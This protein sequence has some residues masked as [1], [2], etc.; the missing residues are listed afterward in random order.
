[1]QLASASPLPQAVGGL[2]AAAMQP[3]RPISTKPQLLDD[4]NVDTTFES[5][6]LSPLL[7]KSIQDNFKIDK[8]FPIQA[9]VFHPVLEGRDVVAKS[10]TGSGKTLAFCLPLVQRIVTEKLNPMVDGTLFLILEPTR[11]LAKQVEQ[12]LKRLAPGV[13][14]ASIYGGSSYDVQERAL[15]SGLHF[16]VA[17]PGRL[18]DLMERGMVNLAS[19]RAVV[20]DE[21]DE[22]LKMGFKEALDT[23]L[24][25]TPVDKQ[26]MLFSATVPGWVMHAANRLCR[27]PVFLDAVG[28]DAVQTS[29][30]IQHY[31]LPFKSSAE[32][33]RRLVAA[34]RKLM[35]NKGIADISRTIVFC[36]T[37]AMCADVST[38]LMSTDFRGRMSVFSIHGDV[39]QNQRER[40]LERFRSSNRGVL[41]AT[42]VAARGIDVSNVELVVCL[43]VPNQ[44]EQY[45]HRS[46]RTGRAG[47]SGNCVLMFT[48]DQ[49]EDVLRIHKEAGAN[50]RMLNV[51]EA[52]SFAGT[53]ADQH[54]KDS[55]KLLNVLPA[56]HAS[57]LQLAETILAKEG[58]AGF[59]K[60]LQNQLQR[61]NNDRP[62]PES[63]ITGRQ[64]WVTCQTKLSQD[65][66]DQHL[67][68]LG[69]HSSK[70]TRAV[71]TKEDTTY[72]DVRMETDFAAMCKD[73][74]IVIAEDMPMDPTLIRQ[75]FM[76][77]H[78]GSSMSR[79]GSSGG[80]RGGSSSYG[81]SRSGGYGG[82]SSGGGYG[83]R[84]SGGG[85]GGGYGGRGGSSGGYG[86]G[87]GGGGGRGGS[88]G[89]YGGGS[90]GGG[91][92]RN[93]SFDF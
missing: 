79:G 8:W 46:G 1:M 81:G 41:V 60:L 30:T 33:S 28:S 34:I 25:S 67:L 24:R 52:S 90:G 50:F 13:R 31:L 83:S 70:D 29:T 12:D 40:E 20:L 65:E 56:P 26:T 11:E 62:S 53:T 38:L 89:G 49:S 9:G 77:G 73:G 18:I 58:P 14:V 42:D 36:P 68:D 71:V 21:T 45:V 19:L 7:S 10:R 61:V 87:S 59:A 74:E 48:P 15:R 54:L 86:G 17:T 72:F 6:P 85:G 32:R 76:A 55:E 91:G 75:A 22:M 64:N 84:S 37:K 35:P 78:G 2:R 4:S 23:I 57:Y 93:R 43:D 16:V 44:P 80:S 92:Y 39:S 63:L 51:S 27:N 5:V 3:C 82:G 66:L 47:N 88:S 69:L